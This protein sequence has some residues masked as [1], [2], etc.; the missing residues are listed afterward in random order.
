[1]SFEVKKLSDEVVKVIPSKTPQDL[2]PVRGYKLFPEINAN[3]FACA[4]KKSGKTVTIRHILRKCCGKDTKI[5]V[6]CATLYKDPTWIAIQEWAEAKGLVFIGHESI[7]DE[8][9]V[10]QL[11]LLVKEL[12]AKAEGDEPQ[13]KSLLDSDSED[14]EPQKKEKYQSPEYIFILDDLSTEL[15]SNSI[16][17][18]LKVN[19]HFKSKTIISSQWLNDLHPM[20]RKQ[21]DYFILFRG[22]P[23]KKLEEIHRDASISIP[24]EDFWKV[25]KFA[26]EKPFSFLYVDC[27]TGEF[28]R[29]FNELIEL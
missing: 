7:K 18:L 19:R 26:T 23:Q 11:E 17:R 5:I 28:R 3:I 9:G 29:N 20:S 25:Y 6:F 21:Q 16:P 14:E 4:K 15:K 10:D 24:L 12:Q 22:H 27:T 8:D 13:E 1:M 2:R